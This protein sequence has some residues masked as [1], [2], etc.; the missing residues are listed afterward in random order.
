M[1]A[2]SVKTT[3]LLLEPTNR[4]QDVDRSDGQ[5]A[6]GFDHD[7]TLLSSQ[8]GEK[9]LSIGESRKLPPFETT[10]KRFAAEQENFSVTWMWK[11]S[12]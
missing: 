10:S 11:M 5:M 8:S 1:T 12:V 9:E 6:P 7:T 4:Q 2:Q 3:G